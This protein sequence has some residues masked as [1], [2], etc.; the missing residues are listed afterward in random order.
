MLS[1]DIQQVCDIDVENFCKS[2]GFDSPP[3]NFEEFDQLITLWEV[4]YAI[5]KLCDT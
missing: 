1:N 2:N 3:C 4:K 5:H